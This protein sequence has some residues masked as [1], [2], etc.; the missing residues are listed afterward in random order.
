M[1]TLS[2]FLYFIATPILITVAILMI[3]AVYKLSN[4]HNEK[5]LRDFNDKLSE[6]KYFLPASDNDIK[7]YLKNKKYK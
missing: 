1:G 5:L 6:H 7:W 4:R 2:I 3:I